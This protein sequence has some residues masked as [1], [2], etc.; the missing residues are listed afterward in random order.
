MA[1][2]KANAEISGSSEGNS[3]ERSL[4]TK[5]TGQS[6]LGRA[7]VHRALYGSS[8]RR[9]GRRKVRAIETRT[10]PSRLSRVS[11]ADETQK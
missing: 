6:H 2:E 3:A 5:E 7:L 9:G 8:S 11:L 10:S 4:N 1:T